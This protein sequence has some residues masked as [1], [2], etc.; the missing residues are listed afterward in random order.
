MCAALKERT[1]NV[2]AFCCMCCNKERMDVRIYSAICASNKVIDVQV[3]CAG[4][5]RKEWMCRRYVV[6]YGLH[7]RK[8]DVQVLC[9]VCAV[10]AAVM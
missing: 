5:I 4:T 8:K 10:C 1:D 6:L 7:Q 9:A 2:S 3:Y